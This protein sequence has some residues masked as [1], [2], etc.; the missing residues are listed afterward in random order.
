MLVL[1]ASLSFA[2]DLMHQGRLLDAAGTPIQGAHTLD[3]DI[4]LAPDG[5]T[6]VWQQDY[7][8]SFDDSYTPAPT[9]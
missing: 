3:V 5:G 4:Y 6:P 1:L 7:A 2:S 9:P 8:V